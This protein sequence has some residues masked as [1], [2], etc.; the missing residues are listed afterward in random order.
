MANE[1]ISLNIAVDNDDYNS[2]QSS[3]EQS[4]DYEEVTNIVNRFKSKRM[5]RDRRSN[6]SDIVIKDLGS[7]CS[8]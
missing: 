1:E 4:S 8:K 2:D 7:V 6:F 3:S 5:R